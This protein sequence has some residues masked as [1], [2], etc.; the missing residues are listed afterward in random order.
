M[1]TRKTSAG[2]SRLLDFQIKEWVK[3]RHLQMNTV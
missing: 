2:V 1:T 3:R